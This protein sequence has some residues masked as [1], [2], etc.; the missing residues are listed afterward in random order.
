MTE[1]L[2][3][4]KLFFSDRKL[5]VRKFRAW[6]GWEQRAVSVTELL[7]IIKLFFSDRKLA[8]RKFR[9]WIGQER[10]ALTWIWLLRFGG[11]ILFTIWTSLRFDNL[12][13]DQRLYGSLF[14]LFMYTFQIG[15]AIGG[16]WKPETWKRP[17]VKLLQNII[18][19]LLL[20]MAIYYLG[21]ADGIFWIL[22][23]IP[24]LS[25][26]RFLQN[27]YRTASILLTLGSSAITGLFVY[28]TSPFGLFIPLTINLLGVAI[29]FVT[30]RT[31]L[32]PDALIDPRSEVAQILDHY[33]SGVCII[34]HKRRIQFVNAGLRRYFG[35]WQNDKT[36]YQYLGCVGENCTACL[37]PAGAAN[38]T[39][40][41]TMI[42]SSG[43]KHDFEITVHHL[44]EDNYVLMFL[45]RPRAVQ[46]ELYEQLLDRIVERDDGGFNDALKQ[47]L[48]SIREQFCAESVALFWLRDGRL[49]R[50]L[51]SGPPLPFS[52][53]Y[54]PGQGV[55]GLTLLR[56][57]NS[58]FGCTIRVNNLDEHPK[59]LHANVS[60]YQQ[61]LPSGK[62]RHLLAV[63][64]SGRH[65]ILGVIRL[66]NRLDRQTLDLHPKGFNHAHEFDLNIIAERL[67]R[68]LEYRE[69]SRKQE[70]QLAETRRFYRIYAASAEKR[71]VFETIVEETMAA[72][73][74]ASKCEIR[75]LNRSQQ[76]LEYVYARHRRGFDYG[77]PPSPIVGINARALREGRIQ[78]VPD[79]KQDADF[80]PGTAPI[81]AMM[82]APLI[83]HLGI[84]CILTLDY[85][86]P[87]QFTPADQERFSAFATHAALVA[88]AFWR[89]EQ[90]ERLRDHIQRI[91]E[92]IG[93]G[94][95][96]VYQNTL[97]AL[98]DLIGYDSASIQIRYGNYLR[99]EKHDGFTD[100]DVLQLIS[101]DINDQRLPNHY[102]MTW[103]NP[104]C[105]ADVRQDYPHF[106]E[107]ADR[108]QSE[109]IRS[110]LYIPLIAHGQS[111][112]MI[113]LDSRTVN[114]YRF[115][116][117]IIGI[118]VASAAASAIENACL[119]EAQEKQR[120]NLS[121][122]LKQS[123]SLVSINNQSALLDTYARLGF[124]MFEC[125]H[126]AIL[127]FP[128]NEQPTI[129]S[130]LRQELSPE[131]V[132]L[133]RQIMHEPE[134][135]HLSGE[136]LTVYYERYGLTDDTFDHLPS[137]RS[138]SLLAAPLYHNHHPIGVVLL[139]NYAYEHENGFPDTTKDLFDLFRRQIVHSL[140]SVNLRQ[141]VRNQLGIDV[142]DM[143]NF[144]QGAV[145]FR[146]NRLIKQLDQGCDSD[147]VSPAL[148]QINRAARYLYQELHHIQDDLRGTVNLERPFREILTEH[149]DFVQERIGHHVDI[150][151]NLPDSI[152][153]S[154]EIATILF[155]ICREALANIAKHAGL[156]ERTDG[157]V[158]IDLHVH[159]ATFTLRIADNGRGLPADR[160][161]RNAEQAYGIYSIKER[162]KRI[163][164]NVNISNRPDGGVMI[165]VEGV[166]K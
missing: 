89:K 138:R 52:E 157:K 67:G 117:I 140:E 41:H 103:N 114:F 139:E 145:I 130:S 66:V 73:P 31:N 120:I 76:T 118:L 124:Q 166:L 19:T 20:S 147:Q 38:S 34:D 56:H 29:I 9:A 159:E 72:F 11:L 16:L 125:E 85:P 129:V 17:Q 7:A 148:Q 12:N 133:A 22:Y 137:G 50:D 70:Q 165:V 14:V 33:Q 71:N 104:L 30:R 24:I 136:Q 74:E 40:R 3:I 32:N 57:P 36:C 144:L 100:P 143:V 44:A 116:D 47:F 142:H 96:K 164:A 123:T 26:V 64:I 88:E 98:R 161:I 62:V 46:L 1:L 141:S 153:L 156:Q 102:V 158:W 13:T 25:A 5:A 91:G 6:I 119:I 107:E 27:P 79:T 131:Y 48:D 105:V 83:G 122:L 149:I 108:Y 150:R 111:I 93:H 160:D 21:S 155:R 69:L 45:D 84:A 128:A 154:P 151:L 23:L 146:N 54:E 60:R 42:D 162:A 61:A 113:A 109:H 81:G 97:D 112:G 94:V 63:P 58:R 8:I 68:A 90:E 86:S 92:S 4:I 99:I 28:Y 49:E 2:V 10:G 127:L 35:E 80:I 53:T 59:V 78:F 132:N 87:R 39:F 163:G 82:V 135:V 101:F 37:A 65:H 110:I 106:Y 18:E 51:T 134:M 126:C 75:R 77:T 115:G 43:R 95:E 55:T 15:T 152:N 121:H